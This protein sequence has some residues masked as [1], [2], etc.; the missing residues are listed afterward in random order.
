MTSYNKYIRALTLENL[1]QLVLDG[2]F[3]VSMAW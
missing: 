3:T 1:L 2:M